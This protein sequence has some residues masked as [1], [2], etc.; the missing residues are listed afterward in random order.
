MLSRSHYFSFPNRNCKVWIQYL[1]SNLK[2]LSIKILDASTTAI[3]A[4]DFQAAEA[5]LK[6]ATFLFALLQK[7]KKFDQNHMEN[8][9][10]MLEE[11]KTRFNEALDLL[12]QG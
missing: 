3:A 9:E 4:H 8:F 10:K 12:Q 1:V 7:D 5:L 2:A 11:R 6:R